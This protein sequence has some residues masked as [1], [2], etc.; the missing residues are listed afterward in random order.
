[1][2]LEM[3]GLELDLK[4]QRLKVLPD[5]TRDTYLTIM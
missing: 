4:N 1:V 2:P 5:D 3:L